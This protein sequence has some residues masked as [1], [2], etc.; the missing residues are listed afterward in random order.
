MLARLMDDE[1]LIRLVVD[2]FLEDL[3]RQITALKAALEARDAPGVERQAHTL[4]GASANVG[5]ER[6]REVAY[7][8]EQAARAGDLNAAGIYLAELEAEG[9]RLTHAMTEVL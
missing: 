5:G 1:E 3:P 7:E 6:L 9:M 8:M 2:G 4:K